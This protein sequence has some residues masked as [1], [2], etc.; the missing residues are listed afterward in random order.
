[1]RPC[2]ITSSPMR[3]S[4]ADVVAVGQLVGRDD[5]RAGRAEP[6]VRLGQRELRRRAGQLE[7]ALGEVLPDRD[8]GDGVPGLRRAGSGTRRGR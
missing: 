4:N 8:P 5:D 6:G 2:W 3:D 7:H 1:M